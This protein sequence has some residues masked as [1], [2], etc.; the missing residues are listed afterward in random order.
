MNYI[1]APPGAAKLR[2]LVAKLGV[3]ARDLI[4]TK[5]PLYRELNSERR[6]LSDDEAVALM[7]AHPELME[8]PVVERGARA[9]VGRPVERVSEFLR[10]EG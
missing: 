6:E 10:R 2:E 5:E 8:R 3:P 1:N 7:V 4:R 9:V